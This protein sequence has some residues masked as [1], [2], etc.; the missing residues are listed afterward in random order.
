MLTIMK[1]ANL[2]V[3]VLLVNLAHGIKEAVV[4]L[5]LSNIECLLFYFISDSD[6]FITL[7]LK[8]VPVQY[9]GWVV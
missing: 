4:G 3:L 2:F 8:L 9:D 6:S 5:S 1:F 7:Y